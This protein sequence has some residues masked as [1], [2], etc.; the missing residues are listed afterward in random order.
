[1]PLKI[2][3]DVPTELKSTS[4]DKIALILRTGLGTVFVTGGWWKL[5]R[6]I[7]TETSAAL[8]DKY[9]APNGYINGF[10]EQFLFTGAMGSPPRQ[11]SCRPDRISIPGARRTKTWLDTD[12]HSRTER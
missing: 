1:M 4:V 10:F 9:M 3:R 6:A 12:K 8:V 5:S 11:T 2:M 7:N